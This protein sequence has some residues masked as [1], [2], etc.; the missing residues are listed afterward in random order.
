V[1]ATAAKAVRRDL[2]RAVGVEAVDVI[3]QTTR[4]VN[5]HGNALNVINARCFRPTSAAAIA[6]EQRLREDDLSLIDELAHVG[7][8]ASMALARATDVDA[9]LMI[10]GAVLGRGFFG[11]L[12]WLLTGK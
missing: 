2:R 9:R 8:D 1:S 11:R 7:R 4:T 6:L 10:A 5:A 12:R 3:E